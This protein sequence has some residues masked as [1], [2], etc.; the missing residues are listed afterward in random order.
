MALQNTNPST[1]TAWKNLEKHFI[2]M[3]NNSIKEMFQTDT[4]RA[5]KFHIQWNDFLVDYSKNNINQETLALLLQLTDE[6]N[7]KDAITKYFDGDIINQTENRA[8]LH[9]ALRAPELATV[10]VNGVNVMPEIYHVK[11]SIEKFTNEITLGVRKGYTGKPF[12]DVV[13]IGIGGSDLGPAMVVE[14]LQYYKNHLNLHFVSNVDGDHV[15]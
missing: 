7:L 9:T 10:L 12:T 11:R 15:N 4:E 3:E 8:V 1:T 5:E 13:N 2:T 6:V 14:A